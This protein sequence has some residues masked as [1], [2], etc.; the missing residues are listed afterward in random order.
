MAPELRAK[1]QPIYDEKI[2]IFSYGTTCFNILVGNS[3]AKAFVDSYD[4]FYKAV[5]RGKWKQWVQDIDVKLSFIVKL[6]ARC[7]KT[8]PN[9]RPTFATLCILLQD[10]L[11]FLLGLR[12]DSSSQ[13]NNKELKAWAYALN[14]Q[15]VQGCKS[16]FRRL[17]Q[18]MD[19]VIGLEMIGRILEKFEG[20][21]LP[22][23]QKKVDFC[24][25]AKDVRLWLKAGKNYG[26]FIRDA[27]SRLLYYD[28]STIL[29]K[30]LEVLD[31]SIIT[32]KVWPPMP[33][34][35]KSLKKRIPMNHLQ[36]FL[37][38]LTLVVTEPTLNFK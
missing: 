19:D 2:D 30:A 4:C 35:R 6:V 36:K 24:D 1:T 3:D 32:S 20:S 12:M 11:R 22:R 8:D 33:W 18:R 37:N 23:V 13:D 5:E 29:E 38:I 10:R 21:E 14:R 25:F 7:W 28:R 9:M 31:P 26:P 27:P 34:W 16:I 17:I 15:N